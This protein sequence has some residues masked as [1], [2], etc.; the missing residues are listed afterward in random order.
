M[1]IHPL[2]PG[3]TARIDVQGLPLVEF[4]DD[5][6]GQDDKVV[7]KYIQTIPGLDFE[8]FM[9]FFAPCLSGNTIG[10]CCYVDGTEVCRI[11]L[12]PCE[13]SAR[14]ERRVKG[15]RRKEGSVWVEKSF[16]FG[17]LTVDE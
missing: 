16:R 5:T 17:N 7:T 4:D 6:E 14:R 3:I 1:A 8:I 2:H 12:L 9:Q 10:A 15:I 11:I 13:I